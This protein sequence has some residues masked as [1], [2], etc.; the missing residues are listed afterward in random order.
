[1]IILE[2]N[3]HRLAICDEFEGAGVHQ[4]TIPFHL[5]PDCEVAEI[6]TG[7]WLI[8]VSD[9]EFVLTYN[10]D[11][12]WQV[13]NRKGW[14][15]PSYGVKL[16]RPVI[17]FQRSGALSSLRVGIYPAEQAPDNPQNWL[18]NLI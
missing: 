11:A 1:K 6:E 14:I 12:D 13:N 4:V 18:V 5:S 8:K 2:K 16:E 10:I 17:E 7:R 3:H 15:S 9:N